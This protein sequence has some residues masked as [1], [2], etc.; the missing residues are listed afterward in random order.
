MPVHEIVKCCIDY[1]STCVVDY[2]SSTSILCNY[3]YVLGV[4]LLELCTVCLYMVCDRYCIF[5][6]GYDMLYIFSPLF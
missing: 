1:T 4:E 2:I 5:H 6:T 3:C